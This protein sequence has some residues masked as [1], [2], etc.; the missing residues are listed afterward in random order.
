MQIKSLKISNWWLLLLVVLAPLLIPGFFLANDLAGAILGPPAIWN[1]PWHSPPS[2]D[3]VG[4]YTESRRRTD[5]AA[6]QFNP[7][8][9]HLEANGHTQVSGLIMS[10]PDQC[11]VSGSGS[12]SGPEDGTLTLNIESDRSPSACK[13]G[14]YTELQL[15]GQTKPYG[16]YWTVG[17]P[18]SGTGIWFKPVQ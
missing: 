15:T 9:I 1:K 6:S 14:S 13:S 17:D 16:L 11:V 10:D 8:T 18:D 12:W 3:V 5:T 2:R 7:A 4:L